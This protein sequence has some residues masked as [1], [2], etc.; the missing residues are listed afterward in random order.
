MQPD[1]GDHL[2][3]TPEV[4]RKFEKEIKVSN[5]KNISIKEII[6]LRRKGLTPGL[7]ARALHCSKRNIKHR[8]KQVEEQV[9]KLGNFPDLREALFAIKQKEILESIKP[10]TIEKA[11]LKDRAIALGIL[12]DKEKIESGKF[13]GGSGLKIEVVNYS[14]ASGVRVTQG[15]QNI[16]EDTD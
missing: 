16:D 12:F 13:A 5:H 15:S 8:L 7:I 2:R 9:N 11:G 10:E 1:G 3:L 14:G 6:N 4:P